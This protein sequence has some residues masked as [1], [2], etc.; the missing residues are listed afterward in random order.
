MELFPKTNFFDL[1][2]EDQG[3]TWERDPAKHRHA[4]KKVAPA[5]SAKSIKAKEPTMHKYI[6][7]FVAS[8]K[9]LGGQ[10]NGIELMTVSRSLAHCN[11]LKGPSLFLT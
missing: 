4:A 8:M 2:G 10:E 3:L 11:K 9:K 5:F 1:G 7:M 6:D